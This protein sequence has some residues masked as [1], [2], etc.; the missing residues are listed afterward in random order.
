VGDERAVVYTLG[1]FADM[2]QMFKATHKIADH[3]V[4]KSG[5]KKVDPFLV[6]AAICTA[7]NSTLRLNMS[8]SPPN[9]KENQQGW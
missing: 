6:I 8:V 5:T 4:I 2:N 9:E 7:I 1:V 3:S